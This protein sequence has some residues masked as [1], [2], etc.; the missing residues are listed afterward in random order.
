VRKAVGDGVA[1]QGNL[2]PGALHCPP[3]EI[4]SRVHE[5]LRQAGPI[6][7]IFN[8]GHGVTPETKPEHVRAMVEAVKEYK[9]AGS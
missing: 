1:L 8:L 5:V 4:R 3:E 7:H 6:G 9:H 2:D